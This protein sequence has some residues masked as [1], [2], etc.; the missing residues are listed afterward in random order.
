M[1]SLSEIKVA[2]PYKIDITNQLD[3]LISLRL[4]R[5]LEEAE[6]RYKDNNDHHISTIDTMIKIHGDKI[7]ATNGLIKQT[8]VRQENQIQYLKKR[9]NRR[10]F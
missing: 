8:H 3:Q 1:K 5:T 4:S 7:L 10:M 9:S 6:E 2:T